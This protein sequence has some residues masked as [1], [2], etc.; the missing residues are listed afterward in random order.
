MGPTQRKYHNLPNKGAGRSSKVGSDS[1]GKKLRFSAFQRWFRIENRTII[2]ET[3]S[4]LAIYD[5]IGPPK[6]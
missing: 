6:L 4:I 1:V 3:V 5:S 2:K